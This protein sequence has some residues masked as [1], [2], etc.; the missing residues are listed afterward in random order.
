VAL[1]GPLT[2][3][4]RPTV[5]KMDVQQSLNTIRQKVFN[6]LYQ[7]VVHT[8]VVD[9]VDD[10]DDDINDVIKGN[11]RVDKDKVIDKLRTAKDLVLQAGHA[12]GLFQ[13]QSE[14]FVETYVYEIF[15]RAMALRSEELDAARALVNLA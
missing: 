10:V 7:V 5:L 9:D 8:V 13:L 4:K 6:Y 2:G 3:P 1:T 11:F 14:P 15:H 12:H